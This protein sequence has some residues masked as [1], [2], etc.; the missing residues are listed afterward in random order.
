[1]AE[2]ILWHKTATRGLRYRFHPTR[3]RKKG[4]KI[5]HDVFYQYRHAV[6]GKTLQEGLGWL[7]DGMT[8][9]KAITRVHEL[10]ENKIHGSGPVT[11]EAK[12]AKQAKQDEAEK[13]ADLEAQKLK[14]T[15]AEIW[16]KYL[17]YSQATKKN[18]R[19]WMREVSLYNHYL[20]R[21]IGK[22]P[23][24]GIAPFHLEKLKKSMADLNRK[25]RTITYALAVVRQVFNFAIKNSIY[26]GKN[27]VSQVNKPAEDNKRTR[28]FSQAEAN[29]LL[30]ELKKQ[31]ADLYGMALLAFRCGLR[32]AEVLKL[33]FGNIDF[34]NE[35]IEIIDTKS[36]RNRFAFMT[37]DVK[38]MLSDRLT[39]TTDP[40][41]TGLIFKRDTGPYLEIPKLFKKVVDRMGFNTGIND[42]RQKLVFHSCRHSFASWHAATG[43]DLHI[44]QK[45]L[46]HETFSMVLR[47]AH[48]RPDTL[49]AAVKRLELSQS[50]GAE[51][52]QLN[53]IKNA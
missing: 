26:T 5:E 39:L 50:N 41:P 13:L 12:R 35:Q 1:M 40:A 20:K 2:K 22:L 33:T 46:G 24:A 18:R 3:T 30:S 6:D 45:L 52:I 49:K 7:F 23:M 27:P 53:G 11:L 43:T 31:D 51:I 44:L 48:L 29:Q 15:F 36:G 21:S 19:G 25:P 17:P 47:Y 8:Y 38:E 37:V 14:I 4:L 28:F 16:E 10:K 42:K 32:A 34:E 9:E